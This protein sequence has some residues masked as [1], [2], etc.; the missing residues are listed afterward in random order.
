MIFT[1]FS[2][3]S[4]S[5]GLA[6]TCSLFALEQVL[7]S[8][9]NSVRISGNKRIE[10][11]TIM[12]YIPLKAGSDFDQMAMDQALKDLYA[13]GYFSDVSIKR[14]GSDLV[15]DIVE[16]ALINKIVFEGNSKLKDEKL[17]EEV[18]LRPREVLSRPKIQAAQQRILD[19]YKRM[20]RF[21]ATVEPKVIK[22]DE[23]RVDLIFEINEG[24]VTYIRKVNFI[25]NKHFNSGKLEQQLFSKRT[26]WYRFFASDDTYDPDRFVADQQVLRQ[27]YYDNG[28]PD[29]RIITAVAELSTDQKDLFLTFTVEEGEEYKFGKVKVDSKIKRIDSEKLKN[30]VYTQEGTVFSAKLIEKTT[31]KLTEEISSQGYAFAEIHPNIEKNRDKKTIDITY[32]INEGPRAYIERID[33]I[34]NDRTR[35]EVIRREMRLQEG[36]AYNAVFIKRAETLINDLGYFKKAEVIT[37]QGS[38]PDKARLIVKVEEQPTGELGLAGGFSTLDGPLANVHF[39]EN[40]LMGTG[41]ILHADFTVARKKQDFDFGLTDPN[42]LNYRLEAGVNFFHTRSTRLKAFT[43]LSKGGAVHIGYSLSEYLYQTLNYSLRQDTVSH[44]D[45]RA[46]RYIKQQQGNYIN[47]SIGQTLSY[48][49]RDSRRE[50]TSGYILSLSNSFAG[51]GGNV[52]YLRNSLGGSLFYTPIEDITFN[53]RGS[54]GCIMRT[55]K[56][57]RIVDS[58]MLGYDTFR[59]FEY[60]GLG[61]RDA[62][63]KDPLGGTRYWTGTLETVFPIGLPN[64][65]GIKGALFSDMGSLWKIGTKKK[66]IKV[67]DSRSVRISVGA[68]L[69]WTSPLGPLRIDYAVPVRKE[70]NDKE[71]RIVFGFSTRF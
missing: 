66:N 65:F 50:P 70:K 11:E 69:S 22:L 12:S 33:I 3:K 55:G 8:P 14:E 21:G 48:D 56:D 1:S 47:S 39:T 4:L 71:Q 52:S 54:V 44:V 41:R 26:R 49:R 19:I 7:A 17:Q 36:D 31:T 9:I 28:Y 30:E 60:G 61:P 38:A 42:F 45:N 58:V 29:F 57:I 37:E 10:S 27:F 15:I 43:Q 5:V 16:N 20:G 32:E 2:P 35:D 13:T 64:E 23:N 62:K 51:L 46:S 18:Q 59:G 6:L 67:D 68:G 34:G 24:E 40:N 53:A 63:T 25:G